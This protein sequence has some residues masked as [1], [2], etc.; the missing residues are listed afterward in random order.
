MVSADIGVERFGRFENI[1][2]NMIYRDVRINVVEWVFV[3]VVNT[4]GSA[5]S[6]RRLR[7]KS[8]VAMQLPNFPT[9]HKEIDD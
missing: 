4:H 9:T 2:K 7:M 1:V 3:P 5:S 6:G 8:N